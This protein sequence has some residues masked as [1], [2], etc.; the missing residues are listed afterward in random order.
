MNDLKTTEALCFKR[1]QKIY[2]HNHSSYNWTEMGINECTDEYKK[3]CN[4]EKFLENSCLKKTV[5]T[6]GMNDEQCDEKWH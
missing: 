3:I 4:S 2:A 1:F 5:N 6:E